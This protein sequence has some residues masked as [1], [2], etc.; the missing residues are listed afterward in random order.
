MYVSLLRALFS[1]IN[2]TYGG[3]GVRSGRIA[4]TIQ[5]KLPSM[6]DV[7]TFACPARGLYFTHQDFGNHSLRRI[8]VV[9]R[10]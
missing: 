5:R 10:Q 7:V 1:D 3:E 2:D 4:A 6:G 9:L 8:D